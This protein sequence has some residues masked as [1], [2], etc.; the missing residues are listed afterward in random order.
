[1]NI[2]E[3]VG[4]STY[5]IAIASTGL[6]I[7]AAIVAYVIYEPNNDPENII[8]QKE[9]KEVTEEEVYDKKYI[10]ELKELDQQIL[11]D[12]ELESLKTKVIDEETPQGLIKM[13]YDHEYK[14]FIWHCDRNHVPY[15]FLETVVRK[16]IIEYN[17]YNLYVDLYDEI[18]KGHHLAKKAQE[19]LSSP[20]D[21]LFV[22]SKDNRE[23]LFKQLAIKNKFLK[24]KYGGKIEEYKNATTDSSTFNIINIDFSTYKQLKEKSN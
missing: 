17:C 11:S 9:Q 16:Y 10:N 20:N 13:Y 23:Q 3:W 14:G 6:F 2:T 19:K 4:K 5:L 7:A 22:K 12:S 8:E 24:F 1:M 21:S 18:E 15:R